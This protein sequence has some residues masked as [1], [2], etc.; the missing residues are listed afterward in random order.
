[1]LLIAIIFIISLF[2]VSFLYTHN[3]LLYDYNVLLIVC[4]VVCLL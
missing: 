4:L 1:M 2:I 3:V